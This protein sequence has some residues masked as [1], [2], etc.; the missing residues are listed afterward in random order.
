MSTAELMEMTTVKAGFVDGRHYTQFV[1]DVRA[2]KRA[3]NLEQAE[4]LLLRLIDATEA[5]ARTNGWGVAPWYYAQ[6]AI[7]YSKQRDSAAEIGILERYERQA[8]SPGAG[9]SKLR[10]RLAALTARQ[11]KASS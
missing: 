1:E 4:R 5:E 9:P 3:G 7:I 2:L 10:D 6:L 11:S 8:K